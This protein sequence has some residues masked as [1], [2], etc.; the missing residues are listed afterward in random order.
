MAA[1]GTS[2]MEEAREVRTTCPYCGVGCGVLARVA[3]DGSVSVR[4]D[5]DHPANFGRLCS[6]G[7][8]LAETLGLEE[9]LLHPEIRGRRTGWDEALDL[10]ASTFSQT[11][12][13]H[14]PD[15]VA[16]YASG[17][18]LTE[19]YYVA[20][21]LMKGFIGSA[22][23]DT[24]SRLCMASSVA[25]HRRAFGSDTVPGC[26]EDLELADLVVLT[27]SN[28]AWCHP[29]LY[30]RL[31]AAKVKRPEMKV[32]LI[33]PRRTITADIAD[34]HLAI[35][36]DGDVAL[37]AGLLGFLAESAVLDRPYIA[38]HTVGFEDALTAAR[39]VSPDDVS[40]QTG[41]DT[42]S[43]GEFYALFAR[44]PKTVTVYSQGVNQSSSG[45]D[46]VNAI[47]NC[48]LA[49]GRIGKPG[50]GPFSV[51]GQPNAM[52]GREVGGLANMLA[53]HMEI[54]N[55][56]HRDRV[57]RFWDA[58]NLAIR[59][60]LKAVDMFRAVAD[61]RIKALWIMATNPVDSVP[62]ADAVEAAIKACPFVVVSDIAAA[63]DTVRHAHVKLPAAAWG[64][65]DGTVTNSERRI[66][67]Q[68]AFLPLP[69]E[70]RPD[71]HII[72]DVAR[73]MGHAEAFT[74]ASPAAIFAEHAALS[75]FENDGKRD[76]DIGA[77]GRLGPA[78]YEALEPFQWPA[79]AG[80]PLKT[81]FFADGG[82][83]T[84]D[85]KARFVAVRPSVPVRTDRLFPYVL[86]TGRVRDQW[87][88]MTRTAKS[89]RLSQHFAEPYAELHPDDASRLRIGDADIVKVNSPGG[90][91]LVRALLSAR[92][93]R[94][95][96]FVPMHWTEQVASS[97][98][99]DRIVPPVTDPL[100]GQ[101]ASKHVA[102]A[103]ERFEAAV[104]GFAVVSER[105]ALI[106]AAYWATARCRG[107]WR[108][109]LAFADQQ[110]DWADFAAR[111]FGAPPEAETLSYQDLSSGQR[112]FASFV[113]DRLIGALFL[114]SEPVAVSRDWAVDQ[115]CRDY[116][117]R[118]A[119]F[120]I[121]AARPGAGT[122]D[123]GATVCSC[124]GI[125]AKQIAGAVLG[126]CCTV[127]AVGRALQA[128]TN[129]GSCRAEIS[130]I[131]DAHRLQAAE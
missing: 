72:A 119:R 114:A 40:R 38:R 122:A 73:R 20:N 46:K 86:N 113:D 41:L 12:A 47:I 117:G 89:V 32:V 124:F 60:G 56:A 43:L 62:D 81:R 52:G 31:A 25:G 129:C 42:T 24:N 71:W 82:Y 6:K 118:R 75:G 16:F 68:R 85:C 120:A 11:I 95:S 87:H 8:A 112:R 27:G 49:T 54:E 33:D 34:L 13:E 26:Y 74:Y 44:T 94:G 36:P 35:A 59:T 29:V 37:F 115:L 106:D 80:K 18:L 88:T 97:A 98:R 121:M 17:Q 104:F 109:E 9:R 63:T 90:W 4:G 125:G 123:R 50:M 108:V 103:V 22:N 83:F 39:A 127:E 58:P 84:P 5:P 78:A 96:V 10:V 23:I 14:G 7:S 61:G 77:L 126:G 130:G 91:I 65:K 55:P 131:I 64:E 101:P 76:F 111:L 19:D 3:A 45:T 116:S 28:L 48:H 53:A 21:K 92:Q 67:R 102:V 2:G 128:G 30:Q 57:Q 107:G 110:H 100:S 66:S 99:V 1:V 15:S 93:Q 79:A 105:P 70:A 69:G 51:T